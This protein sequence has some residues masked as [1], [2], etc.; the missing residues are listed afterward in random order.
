MLVNEHP[1]V[2]ASYALVRNVSVSDEEPDLSD[3]VR[4]I[5]ARYSLE[6]L[7]Q[8]PVVR[9]YRQFFWR[10]KLDPTK[11]RPAGEAVLR[12][13]LRLE[14]I[15][16][17]NNLID[18]INAVAA[19]H[20]AVISAFDFDKLRFPLRLIKASGEE[21][22]KL[23]GGRTF[24]PPR[25]WPILVDRTSRTIAVVFYRDSE[26]AIVTTETKNVV[27]VVYA[28]VALGKDFTER[29]L[30]D[31]IELVRRVSGGEIAARGTSG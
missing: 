2:V 24:T 21:R 30:T 1:E 6:T 14:R 13:V 9:A 25:G 8:D 4:D 5:L 20:A 15:P 10:H 7:T 29:V 17:V 16:H 26:H 23:I 27:I 19:K 31:A 3:V 18:A 22:V 11:I 28:P 12:R